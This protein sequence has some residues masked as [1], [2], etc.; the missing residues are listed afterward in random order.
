MPLA[1]PPLSPKSGVV[2]HTD[3]V[4]ALE[5]AL[6]RVPKAERV[7]VML[8]HA[9]TGVSQRTTWNRLA[10]CVAL[11]KGAERY[12]IFETTGRAMKEGFGLV[13]KHPTLPEQFVFVDTRVAEVAP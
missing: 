1:K 12:G 13:T 5:H 11:R 2:R 9:Q 10:V 7:E 3:R 4:V 6:A 8:E